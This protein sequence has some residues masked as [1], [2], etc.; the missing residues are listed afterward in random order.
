MSPRRLIK[1]DYRMSVR[2][3]ALNP[4]LI[5][6]LMRNLLL[7]LL[8][9]V[10]NRSLRRNFP[11]V[12]QPALHNEDTLKGLFT[13]VVRFEVSTDMACRHATPKGVTGVTS[14]NRRLDDNNF[15]RTM[16]NISSFGLQRFLHRASRL[17]TGGNRRLV[18]YNRLLY[19]HLSR[20]LNIII[21]KGYSSITRNK[22]VSIENFN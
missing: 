3:F 6:G 16:R 9:R 13:K 22:G 4:F 7:K 12:K 2:K 21:L 14:L 1:T 11:R 10:S 5:R 18:R 20:R 19:Y 15:T 17:E 8:T